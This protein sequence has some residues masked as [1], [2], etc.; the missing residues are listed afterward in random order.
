M[1][2]PC[3][4]H[5]IQ[6]CRAS[7]RWSFIFLHGAVTRTLMCPLTAPSLARA[8]S[9]TSRTVVSRGLAPR[10]VD[11]LRVE[12]ARDRVRQHVL[13]PHV[14]Q[15]RRLRLVARRR[16]QVA[17]P[18]HRHRLRAPPPERARASP[19]PDPLG[20]R[21]TTL[22]KG[23][24]LCNEAEELWPPAPR[25]RRRC[26]SRSEPP[27]RLPGREAGGWILRPRCTRAARP[28]RSPP[29]SL[30]R[31]AEASRRGA[32]CPRRPFRLI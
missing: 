19:P 7:M 26:L 17:Q 23:H 25:Y 21:E 30:T 5:L 22:S 2:F 31:S 9:R 29:R 15:R 14:D 20:Q 18:Q 32:T 24:G 27:L 6:Q 3:V 4:F 28:A 12:V 11:H 13:P 10:R 8:S 1:L 16:E